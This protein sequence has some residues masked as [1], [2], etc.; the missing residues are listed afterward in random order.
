MRTFVVLFFSVSLTACVT[1]L[2]VPGYI[3]SPT[4]LGEGVLNVSGGVAKEPQVT[5]K[6]SD[7]AKVYPDRFR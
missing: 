3:N 2:A 1:K 6:D 5:F 4:T 7:D